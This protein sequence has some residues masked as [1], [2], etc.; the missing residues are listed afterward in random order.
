MIPGINSFMFKDYSIEE[1]FAFA[2]GIGCRYVSVQTEH[3]YDRKL[4]NLADKY[5]ITINAA[6]SLFLNVD[7]LSGSL[8]LGKEIVDLCAGNRIPTLVIVINSETEGYE[9]IKNAVIMLRQ[10]C[11]YAAMSKITIAIEPLSIEMRTATCLTHIHYAKMI[12]SYVD[13]D[14]IGIVFDTFHCGTME[15]IEFELETMDANVVAVHLSDRDASGNACFPGEGILPLEK[16]LQLTAKYTKGCVTELEI[17]NQQLVKNSIADLPRYRNAFLQFSRVT[18]IGELAM[19]LFRDESGNEQGTALGGGAGMVAG[20]LS[21]LYDF[22]HLIGIC[23]DDQWGDQIRDDYPEYT[24]WADIVQQEH[25]KSSVVFICG[26]ELSINAGNIKVSNLNRI[27]NRIGN[28]DQYCYLPMFPGYD[29]IYRNLIKKE[30]VRL[31]CDFGFYEWCGNPE[32]LSAKI[33]SSEGGYCALLNARGMGKDEKLS[34]LKYARAEGYLYAIATDGDNE[35]LFAGE[36]HILSYPVF[37]AETIGSTCGAGDCMVA[38]ILH[39]LGKGYLIEE[40][41][42]FGIYVAYKKV[43][44]AGVWEKTNGR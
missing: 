32:I 26:D 9:W 30:N 33:S 42:S 40:A 17:V 5:H 21:C 44:M 1:I 34:L 20:Q 24:G 6:G 19:H 18:V 7:D 13:R 39:F 23:G 37:T 22:P 15:N 11:D 10:L 3:L 38:G 31:I 41:I 14:N 2:S 43:Q 16:L 36:D 12:C 29:S 28:N 8:S 25:G 4:L 35:V 27:L